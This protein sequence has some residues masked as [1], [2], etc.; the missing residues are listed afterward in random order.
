MRNTNTD[1]V[2][3]VFDVKE[4]ITYDEQV[5]RISEKGFVIDDV[6]S[7]KKFLNQ[8]SYYR[9]L[10]YYLPFKKKDGTYFKGIPFSRIQR[11]YEFDS[12]LLGLISEII[13]QIE[14]YLR[15]QLSYHLSHTYGAL[16]YMVNSTFNSRHNDDAFKAKVS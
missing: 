6:N 5:K 9:L 15:T 4:P 16:C 1:E 2:S 12:Q 14:F 13:E 7:C 11:I 8:A 10:A 3:E